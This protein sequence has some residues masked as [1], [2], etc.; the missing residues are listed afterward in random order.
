[1]LTE[2]GH[3][4][5]TYTITGPAAVSHAEM[6]AAVAEAIARPVAFFDVPATAFAGALQSAG[7]PG[8]QVD[9]LLEDYARACI[10]A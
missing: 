4:G 9:G 5:K 7:M 10:A 3:E 2:D 6:A 1:M 8:W